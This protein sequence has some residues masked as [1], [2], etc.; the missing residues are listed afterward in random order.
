MHRITGHHPMSIYLV[1][2]VV[3]GVFSKANMYGISTLNLYL[4]Q[5]GNTCNLRLTL[6]ANA[7][8]HSYF[9]TT[10]SMALR[11]Y[12]HSYFMVTKDI[13]TKNI[14]SAKNYHLHYDSSFFSLVHCQEIKRID[15][16]LN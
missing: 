7:Y 13:K 4:T 10:H 14:T 8:L 16:Y 5:F 3:N 15:D 1:F 6:L 9:I 2:I 11:K 12:C